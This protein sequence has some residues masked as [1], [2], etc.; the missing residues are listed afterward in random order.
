MQ[1]FSYLI[2]YSFVKLGTRNIFF[3]PGK[4]QSFMFCAS[5]HHITHISKPTE[6]AQPIEEADLG[7]EILFDL[8]TVALCI[9][10]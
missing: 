9:Q 3:P 5:L 7:T 4:I 10:G 6:P 1:A 8:S 2:L